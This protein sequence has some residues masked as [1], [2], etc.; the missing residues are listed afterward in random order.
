MKNKSMRD[1]KISAKLLLLALVSVVGL[2]ILGG[3]SVSTARQINQ[4]SAELN[5]V[6]INAVIVAEELNTTTSDYRIQESRHA[7][8]TDPELMAELE[9]EM[10]SI[11]NVIEGKFQ[12]YKRL[13]TRETDQMIIQEAEGVWK[14]Y[15]ECSKV[16]IETSMGNDREKATELMM[17]ESQELFNEASDL[18]LKAVER[19]K[20]ETSVER[21]RAD[22][23]YQRL[24]R[25]KIVVIALVALIVIGMSVY[26]IRG[27][28]KPMEDLAEAARRATSGNLDIELE[29]QSRDEIGTVTEAMNV[30]I[31]RLKDIISDEIWMF[32]EIGSENFDVRSN[33]E[34]AYRG[35]F[36]PILYAFTSL[37]S[38]LKEM[39]RQQD[40]KISR[41]KEEN[42]QL[43]EKL[44]RLEEDGQQKQ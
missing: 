40:E 32:Q 28:R 43:E 3:E 31:K 20:Y 29:Y 33:C 27:I 5:D 25:V 42:R 23:L 13:P 21:A 41:L 44:A 6:W 39:D 9:Q 16:L 8:T 26:L 35:D 30:L 15:L 17:G 14:E 22:E 36:A 18:F 2:C 38:R 34:Q 11:A 12:T 4:V 24:S 19:T 10:R 1:V 7:I 37:Q